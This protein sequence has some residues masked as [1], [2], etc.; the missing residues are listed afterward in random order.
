MTNA[1]D[2]AD[3]GDQGKDE[4]PNLNVG[5]YTDSLQ[6]VSL[7]RFNG[8]DPKKLGYKYFKAT[9]QMTK[10]ENGFQAGDLVQMFETVEGGFPKFMGQANGRV[11]KL[12]GAIAGLDSPAEINAKVTFKDYELATSQEQPFKGT[13]VSAVVSASNP[14][15]PNVVCSPASSTHN[16]VP[17]E[18]TQVKAVA[19][20]PVA[21]E[22][23][24]HPSAPGFFYDAS[25][26][27][28]DG[29]GKKVN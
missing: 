2:M 6:I 4:Y 11:K 13:I 7:R 14:K 27:M 17:G 10:A 3:A 22:R 18:V 25:G 26:A 19:P 1:F 21:L 24:P 9:F 28:F 8:T 15:F 23:F 16:A 12:L 20:P 5:I 29:T